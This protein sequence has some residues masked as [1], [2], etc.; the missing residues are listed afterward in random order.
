MTI[1]DGNKNKIYATKNNSNTKVQIIKLENNDRENAL[2]TLKNK[3]IKLDEI[4][5]SFSEKELKEYLMNHIT[6][7]K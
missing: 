7:L 6:I 3:F 1:F 4:L 5:R 2:K